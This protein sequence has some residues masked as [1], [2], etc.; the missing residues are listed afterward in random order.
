VILIHK[1]T[2]HLFKK[3]VNKRSYVKNSKLTFFGNVKTG[4][5]GELITQLIA[6]QQ[7]IAKK[8]LKKIKTG[9]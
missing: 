9:T 3:N 5:I 7:L 4:Q 8:C 2:I 6:A 1:I